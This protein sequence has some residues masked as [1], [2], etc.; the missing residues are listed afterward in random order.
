MLTNTD[1]LAASQAINLPKSDFHRPE[2]RK[3]TAEELA[4]AKQPEKKAWVQI[5][6]VD[7]ENQPI[8]NQAFTATLPDG[9]KRKGKTDAKGRASFER[10]ITGECTFEF[11]DFTIS[12]K[13]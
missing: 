11:E 8:A 4:T 7:D 6:F 5:E 9:T 3:M 2:V 13:M 1:T 12:A 10:I